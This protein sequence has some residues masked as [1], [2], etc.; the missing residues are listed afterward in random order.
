MIATPT[1][2]MPTKSAS[3][4]GTATVPAVAECTVPRATKCAV[5]R[6]SAPGIGL[7]TLLG[8]PY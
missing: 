4:H 2:S 8:N 7:N 6:V 1:L 5:A 3:I